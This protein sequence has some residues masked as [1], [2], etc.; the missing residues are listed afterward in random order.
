MSEEC[1]TNCASLMRNG[2]KWDILRLWKYADRKG[3]MLL[4][5]LR[6]VGVRDAPMSND[7]LPFTKGTQ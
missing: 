1:A 2:V 3:R 5:T 6:M 7:N 4:I